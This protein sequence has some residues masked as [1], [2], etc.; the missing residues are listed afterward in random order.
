MS[1]IIYISGPSG[2]AKT[3]VKD[4]FESL[5]KPLSIQF[6]RAIV[7]MSRDM[8]SDESQGNLWYFKPLEE[9]KDASKLDRPA[10]VME[11]FL[12]IYEA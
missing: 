9:I 3:K 7:T 1:R 6:E 5:A 8:R 12:R 4:K 2:T 10:R 11:Q